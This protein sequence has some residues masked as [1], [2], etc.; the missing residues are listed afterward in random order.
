MLRGDDV[1]ELQRRLNALGFDAGRE[2]GMLGPE[3]EAAIRLFQREA[4]LATDAVCGPA[5]TAALERMGT[6]AEGSVARVREREAWRRDDRPLRDRR[7][8]LVVEPELSVLGGGVARRLRE[9]GAVVAGPA[10]AH[11]GR[12]AEANQ[13]RRHLRR[14]R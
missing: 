14:A 5:T 13:P 9:I 3:T 7:C 1:A 11:V 6:L 10:I 12:A 2:D 8:F 4:G